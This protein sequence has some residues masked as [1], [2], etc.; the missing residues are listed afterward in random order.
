MR[1]SGRPPYAY[2]VWFKIPAHEVVHI[3]VER[4]DFGGGGF[5]EADDGPVAADPFVGAAD[6]ALIE[7]PPEGIEG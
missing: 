7:N 6:D 2:G 5:G 1:E 4:A 3:P